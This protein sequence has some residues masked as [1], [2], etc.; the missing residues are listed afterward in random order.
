MTEHPPGTRRDPDLHARLEAAYAGKGPGYRPRTQLIGADGRARYVNR[1]I[2]EASPYLLQH[3]HNPVDWRP[4]GPETLAEAAALDRPIFL[5]IGY[6]TCHWC[7]VMEEESFDDEEVA[8][9]LNSGFVP[10]KID[11]EQHP[12]LD[13]LYITATQLQ[14]RHAG[15]P[16][17]LWLMPDGRPFHTGT[18]FPRP[19]FLQV[20][21]AVR[22][23][24]T[25]ASR[26]REIEQVAGQPSDARPPLHPDAGR[27][28]GRARRRRLRPGGR[29]VP[30]H[31][32]PA[33]GRLLDRAAVPAGR[34]SALPAR[35]LAPHRRRR[36]ADGCD[37]ARSTP[38]PRA[39][40][41][42]MSAAASTATLS[43]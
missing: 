39:A 29:A 37:A 13:H 26:R 31:A 41:T 19:Q 16:N 27:G 9:A 32:Q 35:P 11:R 43:T 24:W 6:A 21:A 4:W 42:T 22:A 2:E 3:A 15:W 36:V 12:D 17:S 40:S 23:A 28:R 38:S 5:S 10:V 7:H 30:R 33:R 20:L 14:Q 25:D 18:Y 8:R 1:L 34:L